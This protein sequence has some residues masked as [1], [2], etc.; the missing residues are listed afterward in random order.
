MNKMC[1]QEESDKREGK[2]R[3]EKSNVLM[4]CLVLANTASKHSSGSNIC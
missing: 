1:M 3:I 4:V 2:Y